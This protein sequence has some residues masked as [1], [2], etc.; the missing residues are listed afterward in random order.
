MSKKKII[1]LPIDE[2]MV[3]KRGL[4]LE[5]M[6]ILESEVNERQFREIIDKL[7]KEEYV[8]IDI[9]GRVKATD[10]GIDL[11]NKIIKDGEDARKDNSSYL[12]RAERLIPQMMEY[13]PKGQKEGTQYYWR[14]DKRGLI[15]KMAKWLENY[16]DNYSDEEILEATKAYVEQFGENKRYMSLLTYFI[17][18]KDNNTG[19]ERSMLAQILENGIDTVTNSNKEWWTIMR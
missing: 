2:E 14:A 12:K 5:E 11:L 9:L 18:K 10:K 15:Q 16:N 4:T 1:Y 13:Y 6:L 7:K 19:E 8:H 17:S 3:E